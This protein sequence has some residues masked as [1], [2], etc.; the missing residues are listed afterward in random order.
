[1]NQKYTGEGQQRNEWGE[2]RMYGIGLGGEA[3]EG[4][5]RV[6]Q[7]RRCAQTFPAVYLQKIV[8]TW[9]WYIMMVPWLVLGEV[10]AI[11]T[12]RLLRSW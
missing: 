7:K 11:S 2:E 10:H 12:W 8:P 3:G 6:I 5:R 4:W 1:M 9:T